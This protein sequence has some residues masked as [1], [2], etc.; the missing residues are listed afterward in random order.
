MHDAGK[1]ITGLVIFVAVVTFP[2][3]FTLASGDADF[4]PDPKLPTD[5]K[6][7]VESKEYMKA[8]HMDLLNQ[9][10]D[11]VV[12]DTTRLYISSNGK[13]YKMSLSNTCMK[14]HDNKEKFCDQCHNYIGVDPYCWDCHVE[15]KGE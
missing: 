10:R 13:Q 6:D 9:W 4:R 7:C 14:C 2:L 15:P 12:R 8:W 11:A 5:Q 1:I 3:W